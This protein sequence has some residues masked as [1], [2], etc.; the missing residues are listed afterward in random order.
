MRHATPPI[1]LV[2][3]AVCAA[4]ALAASAAK[5]PMSLI[6]RKTD[7]PACTAYEADDGD[8][9]QFKHPLEAGGVAFESA[10]FQCI[11]YSSTKG[12]LH[13]TGSVFVTPSLAQAKKGFKLMSSRKASWWVGTTRPLSVP[14]NGDQQY[15]LHDPAGGEGIW[16]A[17]FVVRKRATLWALRV[18]HERRPAISKSAFLASVNTYARKLRARVGNG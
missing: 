8:Y 9:T 10:T 3:A 5:D 13:V 16:I 11:S 14:S 6:L 7:F 4:S 2:V 1:A 17:N 15:V 18:L 12:S